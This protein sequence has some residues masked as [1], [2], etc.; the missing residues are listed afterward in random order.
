MKS[1]YRKDHNN[2]HHWLRYNFGPA[3]KCQN[4]T[5]QKLSNKFEYALKKGESHAKKIEN[6]IQLCKVCHNVYDENQ[7]KPEI[8]YKSAPIR[9]FMKNN[10]IAS[11]VIRVY[12]STRK[13]LKVGAAKKEQTLA[14]YVEE[15][16]K[17][18]LQTSK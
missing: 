12:P 2:I 13:K 15:L 3:K 8:D 4:K 16:T 10:E 17:T 1:I 14:A 6:Y 7:P 9:R 5:C 18:Q 11:V